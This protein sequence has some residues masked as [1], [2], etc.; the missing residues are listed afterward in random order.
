MIFVWLV[1]VSLV[2]GFENYSSGNFFNV[3]IVHV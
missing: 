1:K 2:L 3:V